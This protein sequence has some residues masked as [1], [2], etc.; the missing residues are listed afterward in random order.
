M[1]WS[2]AN[3]RSAFGKVG[4]GSSLHACCGEGRGGWSN[5]WA[6]PGSDAPPPARR[7]G[8]TRWPPRCLDRLDPTRSRLQG[9][10][11]S[12]C[13]SRMRLRSSEC[14]PRRSTVP[15]GI[16]GDGSVAGS[17]RRFGRPPSGLKREVRSP[18][19]G[20]GPCRSSC[21][22]QATGGVD[23]TAGSTIRGCLPSR[24][25]RPF[26]RVDGTGS[27]VDGDRRRSGP[28][29]GLGDRSPTR[30][31][32]ARCVGLNIGCAGVAGGTLTRPCCSS[33]TF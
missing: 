29:A 9:L 24:W 6:M 16:R 2:W 33:M 13:L 12:R 25:Q 30:L 23:G 26:A 20:Y 7:G 22:F 21:R 27:P 1:W 18:E 3:R 28:I 4:A 19:V 5:R 32:L 8:T 15:T 11:S 10:T 31:R 14:S 17:G